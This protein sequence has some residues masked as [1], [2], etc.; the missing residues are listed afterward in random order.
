MAWTDRYRQMSDSKL[1]VGPGPRAR[2]DLTVPVTVTV[3]RV[4]T[5][6]GPT[7]PVPV[8]V[9]AGDIIVRVKSEFR[10]AGV[11]GRSLGQSPSV[12]RSRRAPRPHR[13]G[14]RAAQWL[15]SRVMCPA[16]RPRAW[17]GPQAGA[18]DSEGT[19]TT[20]ARPRRLPAG[21]PG[22]GPGRPGYNPECRMMSDPTSDSES[23]ST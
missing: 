21:G 15:A 13:H 18:T 23:D 14:A 7:I 19:A 8:T 12:P 10:H 11:P 4:P 16:P 22:P 9:T 3:A 2:R 17:A 6:Q 1:V 20:A 5:G